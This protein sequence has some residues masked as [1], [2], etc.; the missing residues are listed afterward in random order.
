[1]TKNFY[2]RVPADSIAG[3]KM[4]RF[5]EACQ[6]AEQ[7]AE[8]FAAANGAVSYY[9]DPMSFAGGVVGLVFADPD[10]VDRN[11]W[12]SIGIQQ[13]TGEM[14][15]LPNDDNMVGKAV[16]DVRLQLPV[17]KTDDLYYMLMSEKQRH[18]K[19]KMKA[20]AIT[21]VFFLHDGNYYGKVG[22]NCLS[23]SVQ[24]ITAIEFRRVMDIAKG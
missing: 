22:L 2:Y 23:P 11:E 12:S 24:K 1:M 14:L 3:K 17:T 4:A 13:E 8:Q 7:A 5:H 10:K 21:P 6:Q 15:F 20:P 16:N 18:K 19:K 9:E